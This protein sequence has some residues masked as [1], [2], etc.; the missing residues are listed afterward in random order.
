MQMK[1]SIAIVLDSHPSKP[2]DACGFASTGSVEAFPHCLLTR[3]RKRRSIPPIQFHLSRLYKP[4]ARGP[5]GRDASPSD[6]ISIGSALPALSSNC[7][8]F[9]AGSGSGSVIADAP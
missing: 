9:P 4:I 6:S 7:R 3:N 8:H 5:S 1:R 2:N